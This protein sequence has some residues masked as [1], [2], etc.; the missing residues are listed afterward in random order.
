M[1]ISD[2]SSDVCSSNLVGRQAAEH[3]QRQRGTRIRRQQRMA[4]DEHETQQIVA[5]VIV[6]I[7][8]DAGLYREQ[9]IL[10]LARQFFFLAQLHRSMA[11][12]DR[13]STRLN[14]SH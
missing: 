7:D 5:N 1:R 4:G 3:L 6:E 13:K 10:D 12:Q 2:W 8:F 9:L 11:Q 14:S